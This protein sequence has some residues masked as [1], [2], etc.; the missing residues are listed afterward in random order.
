MNQNKRLAT[1]SNKDN[2]KE[3]DKEIF[4]ELVK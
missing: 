4:E 3:N 2:H 1:L